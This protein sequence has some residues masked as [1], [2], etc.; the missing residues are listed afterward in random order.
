MD[1]SL[2]EVKYRAS[3]IVLIKGDCFGCF[4]CSNV[5]P[6][7]GAI[8][9]ELSHPVGSLEKMRSRRRRKTG[10]FEDP[11]NIQRDP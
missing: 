10:A 2:G 7:Q 8:A 11:F 9:F 5:L 6:L 1:G 4:A 3:V